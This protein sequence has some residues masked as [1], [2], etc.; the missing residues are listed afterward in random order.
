MFDEAFDAQK[1]KSMHGCGECVFCLAKCPKC[2]SV[3][4][5][6]LYHRHYSKNGDVNSET[7]V[8]CKCGRTITKEFTLPAEI[9]GVRTQTVEFYQQ[10][11]YYDS[12]ELNKIFDKLFI[13]CKP[14]EPIDVTIIYKLYNETE[15][16]IE[17]QFEDI[18]NEVE[19][20]EELPD[21]IYYKINDKNK[22]TCTTETNT[23]IS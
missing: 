3:D 6:I 17:L 4:V 5:Q 1:I 12:P 9:S 23:Y 18:D 2:S 21:S 22:I 7:L 16:V 14:K 13:E 11:E 8:A 20:D 19:F 10:D 15:N